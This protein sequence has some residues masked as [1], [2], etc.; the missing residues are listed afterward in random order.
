MTLRDIAFNAAREGF[1]RG[2]GKEDLGFE[3]TVAAAEHFAREYC[4]ARW[5][6][7]SV[8]A[9]DF[10]AAHSMISALEAQR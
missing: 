10:S 9:A 7:A 8:P 2:V 4:D 1:M 5:P 6:V 3:R